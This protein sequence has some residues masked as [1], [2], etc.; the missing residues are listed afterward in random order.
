[1]CKQS[2]N[3]RVGAARRT[4]TSAKVNRPS[5]ASET[6]TSLNYPTTILDVWNN[7]V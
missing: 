6:H 3:F 7:R 2:R 4:P 1:M 5:S